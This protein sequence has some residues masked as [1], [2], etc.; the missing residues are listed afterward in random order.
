[1]VLVHGSKKAVTKGVVARSTQ[2]E[3]SLMAAPPAPSA[4][5]S[6]ISEGRILPGIVLRAEAARKRVQAQTRFTRK[7]CRSGREAA[8]IQQDRTCD[9]PGYRRACERTDHGSHRDQCHAS[10]RK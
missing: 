10:I 2:V 6:P 9:Q 7:A 5:H 8:P 3:T 4:W 1:M